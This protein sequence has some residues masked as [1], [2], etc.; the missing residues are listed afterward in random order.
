MYEPFYRNLSFTPYTSYLGVGIGDVA[1]V[2]PALAGYIPT[3]TEVR[4]GVHASSGPPEHFSWTLSD[5]AQLN[6][7]H[8]EL[9][10]PVEV[11][12][13]PWEDLVVRA[14]TYSLGLFC[15][16]PLRQFSLVLAYHHADRHLRFLVYHSGGLTASTPLKIDDRDDCKEI[17]RL[18]SAILT[19]RTR[20]DAGLPEWCDHAACCLPRED[21]GRETKLGIKEVLQST[22]A[23][24]G[25]RPEIW[26][27]WARDGAFSSD[28]TQGILASKKR[29]SEEATASEGKRTKLDGDDTTLPSDTG[30]TEFSSGKLGAVRGI[31]TVQP[32]AISFQQS[33]V[34]S[35]QQ[36]IETLS[37]DGDIYA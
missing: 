26:R 9:L 34:R 7:K 32:A 20:G 27:L 6:E 3:K 23:V 11:G 28:V 31:S 36:D 18:F 24:R 2:K 5:R 8:C 17:L 13:Q 37:N 19:W 14:A 16:V 15:A 30:T 29:K 12:N 35:I 21:G 22:L 1:R 4:G 25:R 33:K 10:I